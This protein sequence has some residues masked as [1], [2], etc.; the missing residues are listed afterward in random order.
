MNLPQETLIAVLDIGTSNIRASAVSPSGTVAAEFRSRFTTHSP[1]RGFVEFDAEELFQTCLRLLKCLLSETP[2]S[3]IALTNQR[4]STVVFDP[5]TKSPVC[6]GQSWQDLR[7]APMC[8]A[9]KAPGISLSPNQSATKISLMMDLF[10][11]DRSRGLLGGTI[12][13]WICFRLTGE[14]KTDHTNAAMT[15]LVEPTVTRYDPTILSKLNIPLK[16]LPEIVPSIGYL[17]ETD[18]DGLIL[19]LVAMLGDQQASMLGQGITEPKR[20]KATFGTGAMVDIL[21]GEKG[22][23]TTARLSHGTFPIVARSEGDQ[24]LFGLEAI[25]LHAGSAIDFV[26]ANLGIADSPAS[27]EALARESHFGSNEV[28]VPALTGLATPYWD[29]GALACFA[30]IT[31]LTTRSDLANATLAGVAHMGADLI[32]AIEADSQVALESL[33][34]DGGMTQNRLFLQHLANFSQKRLRISSAKEA[35]SI[36]AG[37]AGHLALGT[38]SHVSCIDELIMPKLTVDPDRAFDI[39]QAERSRDTWLKAVEISRNSVPELSTVT[40]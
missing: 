18:I 2:C 3:A 4:A 16:A 1:T 7:T 31:K 8:L 5:L 32:E 14:F 28:F 37:L 20:A 40:F 10:D 27:I 38:L 12:D 30:N 21:T 33:S 23:T 39:R 25:G 26:C 34:V 24:I 19:P 35:T 22:P 29:F 17:G 6:M 9:L 15:G 36:G 11:K 13:A